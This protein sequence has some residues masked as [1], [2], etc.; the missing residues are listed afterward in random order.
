MKPLF[1]TGKITRVA[2]APVLNIGFI[3]YEMLIFIFLPFAQVARGH[4]VH[5]EL[6][7]ISFLELITLNRSDSVNLQHSPKIPKVADQKQTKSPKI[8]LEK[9]MQYPT[10]RSQPTMSSCFRST[11]QQIDTC[12]SRS[13]PMYVLYRV[14]DVSSEENW[15]FS[16]VNV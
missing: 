9:A 13:S 5:V 16:L 4:K 2:S 10:L 8:G 15:R 11:N 3:C 1:L 7:H 14:Q 6:D 12:C